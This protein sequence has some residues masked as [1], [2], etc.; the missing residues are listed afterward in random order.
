M[1]WGTCA[2][3]VT[4]VTWMTT[5]GTTTG[6]NTLFCTQRLGRDHVAPPAWRGLAAQPEQPSAN[7]NRL[8]AS[9]R[10]IA[11]KK[12]LFLPALRKK[13]ALLVCEFQI[14]PFLPGD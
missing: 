7:S 8:K 13:H 3:K 9:K 14:V 2:I 11:L 5:T 4:W 12:L 6:A 10:D 1:T